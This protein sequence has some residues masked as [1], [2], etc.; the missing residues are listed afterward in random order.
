MEGLSGQLLQGLRYY[1]LG[2]R[3]EESNRGTVLIHFDGEMVVDSGYEIVVDVTAAPLIDSME[4]DEGFV[5]RSQQS[6]LP[7][8]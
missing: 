4:L 7:A 5:Y 1:E 3:I 6:L 8:A 2:D